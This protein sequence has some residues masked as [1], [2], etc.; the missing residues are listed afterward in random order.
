[1]ALVVGAEA[2]RAGLA[3]LTSPEELARRVDMTMWVP[4]YAWLRSKS[5]ESFL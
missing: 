3:E 4:R 1:V 2:Q 5:E